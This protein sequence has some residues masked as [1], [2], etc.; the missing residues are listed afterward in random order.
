MKELELK[1]GSRTIMIRGNDY[2]EYNEKLKGKTDVVIKILE[3]WEPE[4]PDFDD[5]EICDAVY[6]LSIDEIDLLIEKLNEAKTFLK[7]I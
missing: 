5:W 1:K 2:G 7:N 4:D 6:Y 3:E